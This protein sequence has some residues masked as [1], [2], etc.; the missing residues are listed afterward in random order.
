M[1][2]SILCTGLILAVC[3]VPSLWA[4]A[5]PKPTSTTT[6]TFDD[7]KQVSVRYTEDMSA[8]KQPSK[9]KVWTPGESPV[10]LFSQTGLLLGNSVIP[11]DAYSVYVIPESKQWTLVVSKNVKPGSQYDEAQDLARFPMETGEV[12][13]PEK[14]LSFSFAHVAP[15]QCNMRLYY[16]DTG[17]WAEFKEQ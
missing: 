10:F 6:C 2:Y 13:P 4:Q 5:S 12:N 9:G 16:G 1:R 17:A 11:A 8:N 7:G 14:N 3:V 15:K